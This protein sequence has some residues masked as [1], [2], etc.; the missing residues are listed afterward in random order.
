MAEDSSEIVREAMEAGAATDVMVKVNG[1]A[2][3]SNLAYGD[4]VSHQRA[5]NNKREVQQ[6]IGIAIGAKAAEM[7]MNMSVHEGA[8]SEIMSGFLGKFFQQTP[9]P[10][11]VPTQGESG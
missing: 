10:T 8:S 11:N 2:F 1:P 5:M 7:I 4:A 6:D 9:P 3:L